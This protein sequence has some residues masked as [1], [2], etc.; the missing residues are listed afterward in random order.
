MLVKKFLVSMSVLA[1]LGGTPALVNA[2]DADSSLNKRQIFKTGKGVAAGQSSA[3]GGAAGGGAASGGAFGGIA[4]GTV[5]AGVA[6]A[7]AVAVAVAAVTDDTNTT[8]T[9]TT[10][11]TCL[12]CSS[13]GPARANGGPTGTG[14]GGAAP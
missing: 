5:A 8:T 10:T 1:L 11:A 6:V 13:F 9:T 7:A 14:G 4:A 12:E 3:S 2:A